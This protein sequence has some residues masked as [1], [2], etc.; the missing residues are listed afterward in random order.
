MFG[1]G[2]ASWY[3]EILA[4]TRAKTEIPPDRATLRRDPDKP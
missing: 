1:R 4:E 2:T 3:A